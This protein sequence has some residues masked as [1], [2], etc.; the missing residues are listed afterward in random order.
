M[1][2][3]NSVIS[4]LLGLIGIGSL[5]LS[6]FKKQYD[7]IDYAIKVDV[8]GLN[9]AV[10]I[11]GEQHNQT[12]VFLPGMGMVSPYIEYKSIT[13]PLTDEYRVITIEPFGYGLSDLTDKERTTENIVSE[14]HT[15]LEKLGVNQ[16]IFMA[17][18]LGGIYSL[19]YADKYS[20]EVLGFIGLDNTPP[21]HPVKIPEYY[22]LLTKISQP[23]SDLHLWRF[24]PEEFI[25]NNTS[26]DPKYKYTQQEIKDLYT[27]FGYNF[28]NKNSIN[29]FIHFCDNI[30]ATRDMLFNCPSIMFLSS[31][32]CKQFP[33]WKTVHDDIIGHPENSDVIQLEGSHAIHI[34]QREDIL[35]RIREWLKLIN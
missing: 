31:D 4:T 14:I 10:N 13:E 28:N 35:K 17:H 2:T 3:L 20:N 27:I 12:I 22:K 11:S 8:N 21:N 18:S 25:K 16:F 5:G 7:A 24:A 32:N 1:V 19:A 33:Y 34:D 15:C 6:N 30:Q 23:I 9:M 26:I 29:E